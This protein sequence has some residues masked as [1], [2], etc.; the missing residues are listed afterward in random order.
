MNFSCENCQ[1]RYSIADEKVRGK[2]V[3]VRCKNCQNVITLSAPAPEP[4]PDPE[5]QIPE[6]DRTRMVSLETIETLR[7]NSL[8][9]MPAQT[10]APAAAPPKDP[11]EDEPTRTAPPLDTTAQWFVMV[12]GKQVGPLD[13]AALMDKVATGDVAPRSYMW[14]QGMADWKRAA[15]IPELAT[16]L[17]GA[18]ASPP[19][20]PPPDPEPAARTQPQPAART[21]P[22]RAQPEPARAQ[23]EPARAQPEPARAQSRVWDE[24]NATDQ[25]QAAPDLGDEPRT[26]GSSFMSKLD[27]LPDGARLG[28]RGSD[29][30]SSDFGQDESFNGSE[31]R[32]EAPSQAASASSAAT[33]AHDLFSDL[34]L[35]VNKDED[36]AGNSGEMLSEQPGVATSRAGED[37]FAALGK[38]DPAALGAKPAEN[39]SYFIAKSGVK[40]R[41]PPWKIATFILLLIAL[42][43]GVLYALSELKVVP[44]EVKRVNAQG[45]EVTQSVFSAEGASALRDML[46]GR[47]K[48]V[49]PPPPEP[50]PDKRPQVKKEQ[51]AGTT[52]PAAEKKPPS[53]DLADLYNDPNKKD[54]GPKVRP[55]EQQ[56]APVAASGSEGPPEAEVAK[57]VDQHQKAFQDCI[58]AEMKKNPAFRGGKVKLVA[59]IGSSGVV[60]KASLDRKEIDGST[61]GE[62]IKSRARRMTFS[63][64]SGEDVDLEI[65]LILSTTM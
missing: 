20:P 21:Q 14:K 10:Q 13:A 49:A 56:A 54:V 62:C 45:Q 53:Q 25:Q 24:L 46:L 32:A 30:G 58:E 37:P 9:A 63:A 38:A 40:N 51:P 4:E 11:W 55:G 48:P 59:T 22:V 17:A 50:I 33:G 23:P 5:L 19:P 28:D 36:T 65:P 3:K 1:R 43:V 60:K 31:P 57:V 12:K 35:G 52:Q 64:F 42:P 18:Q 29:D 34:D 47:E 2:T 44:L 61:L 41:N 6:E 15:D 27:S 26:D 16:V 8:T 39:T 7:A